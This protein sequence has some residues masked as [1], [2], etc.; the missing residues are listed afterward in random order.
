MALD[1]II[2]PAVA[3]TDKLLPRYV[4][5]EEDSDVAQYKSIFGTPVYGPFEFYDT[6]G[7]N[8]NSKDS[9]NNSVILRI[10]TVLH[11]I[12]Q[13]KNIVK[14]AIQGRPGTIKEYVGLGDYSITL[15]GSIVAPQA[16]KFPQDDV[17]MLIRLLNHP[18]QLKVSSEWLLLF[19]I[20]FVVVDDYELGQK[21]GSR[22]EVPFKIMLSSDEDESK[23][24]FIKQ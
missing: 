18:G 4:I 9:S 19:G 14:T 22:N 13:T 5:F 23:D 6:P 17:D 15:E 2:P 7:F 21:E 11:V 16:N 24:L 12:N 10:D 20:N 8:A 3:V 1:Y